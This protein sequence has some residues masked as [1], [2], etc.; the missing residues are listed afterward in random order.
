MVP[1]VSGK[2]VRRLYLRSSLKAAVTTSNYSTAKDFLKYTV[3]S[4]ASNF[5]VYM[6][7]VSNH[8]LLQGGL[9]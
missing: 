2:V 3:R 7:M 9:A 1:E 8:T 6:L 5:V 4:E